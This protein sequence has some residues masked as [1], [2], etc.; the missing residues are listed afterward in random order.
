[1]RYPELGNPIKDRQVTLPIHREEETAFSLVP[2]PHPLRGK[3]SGDS[4][5]LSFNQNAALQF[6]A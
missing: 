3:G 2:R 4:R 5:V 1:M 6:Y